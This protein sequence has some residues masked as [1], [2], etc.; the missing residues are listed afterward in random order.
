MASD[1][2]DTTP[3]D[4]PEPAGDDGETPIGPED[5]ALRP[6][7]VEETVEDDSDETPDAPQET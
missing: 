2:P 1:E 4:D 7:L 3:T 6:P 5:G